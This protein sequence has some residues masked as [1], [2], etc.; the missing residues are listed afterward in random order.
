MFGVTSNAGEP[1]AARA[2]E[3]FWV[4]IGPDAAAQLV[5][6]GAWRTFGRGRVLVHRGQVSDR[7]LL[8]RQGRVKVTTT[9]STG[10][11]VVLAFRGAGDLLGELSAFGAS[12]RSATVHAI[13][14]VEALSVASDVFR[15]FVGSH[16]D[17]AILLIELLARRLR[18]SDAKRIE[19]ST[20]T[21]IQRVASGLLEFAQRFGAEEPGG[22]RIA[23]PLTQEE[24]A[25]AT[26]CSVESVGRALQTMRSLNCVETGR[27]QI[28][29]LDQQA[30]RRF[31]PEP[32]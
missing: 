32:D 2:R 1:G 15:R 25:G 31:V 6:E 14:H 28:R 19:L 17:V 13:D 21:A 22:I 11:E 30:L 12:P 4:A 26:G 5:A 18:D 23:L 16:P 29:I 7:V 3:D 9:T 20:S 24:L 10:R 27:R 8:L